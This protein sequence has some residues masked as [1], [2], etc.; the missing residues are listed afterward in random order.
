[1]IWKEKEG[2]RIRVVQI[3]NLRGLLGIRRI[4]KVL[5]VRIR[6]LF[7]MMKGIDKRIV[8]GVLWWLGHVERIENERIAKRLYIGEC[9]GSCS[10]WRL[11]KSCIDTV[12]GFE[13]RGLDVR[14]AREGSRIGVN[15]GSL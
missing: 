6:K 15:V 8:E 9:T 12:K 7:G 4:D 10:V 5:N 2:A 3:D 13:K 1:M 11:W 14:Q